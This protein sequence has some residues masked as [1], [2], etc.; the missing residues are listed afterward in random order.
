[1]NYI[2][3]SAFVLINFRAKIG[4]IWIMKL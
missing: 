2:L 1:V 4:F 3:L